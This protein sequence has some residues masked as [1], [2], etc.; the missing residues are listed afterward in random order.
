M[1]GSLNIFQVFQSAGWVIYA[2]SET[3]NIISEL[4]PLSNKTLFNSWWNNQLFKYFQFRSLEK[5]KKSIQKYFKSVN[6][7]HCELV[8]CFAFCQAQLQLQLQLQ[9][10][11][12]LALISY[13]PAPTHPPTTTRASSE[14]NLNFI[15]NSNLTELELGPTQPQLVLFIA[16]ASYWGARTP[17]NIQVCI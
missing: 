16:D 13:N 1:R 12:R 17:K 7:R 4:S 9:L 10:E 3:Q 6:C 15:Y 8:N 2:Y 5:R 14:R 11:L